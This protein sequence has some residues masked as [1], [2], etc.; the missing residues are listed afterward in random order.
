MII[1]IILTL[2]LIT[3]NSRNFV[4]E[5]IDDTCEK[6]CICGKCF[7]DNYLLDINNIIDCSCV[8]RECTMIA[9]S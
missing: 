8:R 1:V 7:C 4:D 6:F 3:S 9:V 2:F 5:K